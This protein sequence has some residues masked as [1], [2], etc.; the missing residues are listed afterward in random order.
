MARGD[1]VLEARGGAAVV[2]GGGERE[3]EQEREQERE[4]GSS[5]DRDLRALCG[6]A[7]ART[8]RQLADVARHAGSVFEELEEEL[9]ADRAEAE[10][11]ARDRG[12]SA[13]A[14]GPT[15]GQTGGSA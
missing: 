9:A 11:A 8:L 3:R 2:C 1:A 12:Q 4:R 13:A 15:G 6:A 10:D 5:P 7:L 14:R